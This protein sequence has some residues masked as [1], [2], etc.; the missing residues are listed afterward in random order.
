M[1]LSLAVAASWLACSTHAAERT[2]YLI[3]KKSLSLCQDKPAEE[4]CAPDQI[5]VYYEQNQIVTRN[6]VC[7]CKYASIVAMS[8]YPLHPIR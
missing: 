5:N 1:K 6:G 7:S 2:G 8:S 4:A 3:D